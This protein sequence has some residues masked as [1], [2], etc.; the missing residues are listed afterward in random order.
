MQATTQAQEVVDPELLIE[1]S[2][3]L[4]ELR[5]PTIPRC[6]GQRFI[7]AY[8]CWGAIQLWELALLGDAKEHL[9][10]HAEGVPNFGHFASAVLAKLLAL[11]SKEWIADVPHNPSAANA[12]LEPPTI[13]KHTV[14]V[15]VVVDNGFAILA[16]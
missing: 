12:I 3:E 8:A 2:F 11:A 7:E 16:E 1:G 9:I 14:A 15:Q 4:E 13:R 10:L 5:L 6:T